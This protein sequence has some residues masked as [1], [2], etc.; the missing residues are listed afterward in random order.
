MYKSVQAQEIQI[1]EFEARIGQATMLETVMMVCEKLWF[2]N[3][4]R[5]NRTRK[6]LLRTFR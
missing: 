4:C 1:S 5:T 2:A 6:I 3:L